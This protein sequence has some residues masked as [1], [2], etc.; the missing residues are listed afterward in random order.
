MASKPGRAP[1]SASISPTSVTPASAALMRTNLRAAPDPAA[2]Q[3]TTAPKMASA[4]S[5]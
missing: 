4:F 1:A 5:R 3:R 2:P